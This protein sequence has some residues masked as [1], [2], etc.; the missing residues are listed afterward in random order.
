VS[1][2]VPSWAMNLLTE[3]RVARLGTADAAGRPLVVPICYAYDG[4]AIYSAVDAKPKRTR[5]LRRLRN[6]VENPQVALVVDE[7]DEEWSRLRWVIV[8]GRA[9]VV[10]AASDQARALDLLQ[11]KYPQY[12]ALGLARDSPLI[13]IVP[14][15]FLTWRYA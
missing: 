1:E 4:R 6:I 2:A 8:E 12:R 7:Y 11:T 13:R 15:R 9:D 10:D 5:Q 14:E 3:G